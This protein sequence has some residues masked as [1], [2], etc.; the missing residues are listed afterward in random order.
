LQKYLLVDLIYKQV[1]CLDIACTLSEENQ[2]MANFCHLYIRELKL[3]P[4]SF[5]FNSL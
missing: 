4:A 3:H 1:C 5:K 2:P